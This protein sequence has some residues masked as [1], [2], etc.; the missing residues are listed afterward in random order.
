MFPAL[1]KHVGG[2]KFDSD[3]EVQKEV[4]TW[5]READGEWYSAGIDKFIVRMRKVLEKNGDYVESHKALW[6]EAKIVDIF[7][8][9]SIT[10]SNEKNS[11]KQLTTKNIIRRQ[12]TTENGLKRQRTA[13]NNVQHHKT[14]E[15]NRKRSKMTDNSQKSPKKNPKFLGYPFSNSG[16]VVTPGH[17][18]IVVDP[19][20]LTR[21]ST[22]DSI[23]TSSPKINAGVPQGSVLARVVELECRRLSSTKD[24]PSIMYREK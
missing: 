5:L 7:A 6:C 11:L 14:A 23:S 19:N 2:K 15:N 22:I 24:N 9:S 1:K 13:K 21:D 10:L 3:A 17:V 16:D 20:S 18:I 8:H 12:K 4:N